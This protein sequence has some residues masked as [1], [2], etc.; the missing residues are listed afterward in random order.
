MNY[1]HWI[2]WQTNYIMVDDI[3]YF[4]VGNTKE[5]E[6]VIARSGQTA[7]DEAPVLGVIT[8]TNLERICGL[9]IHFTLV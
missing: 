7:T 8:V 3:A 2:G 1:G 4:T 5:C 6:M 9:P